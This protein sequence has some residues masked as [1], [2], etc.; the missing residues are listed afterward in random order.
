MLPDISH[1]CAVRRQRGKHH[2]CGRGL[3][4]ELPQCFGAAMQEPVIPASLLTPDTLGVGEDQQVFPILGPRVVFNLKR[5]GLTGRNKL[6]CRDQ[7]FAMPGCWMIFY[8]VFDLFAVF[9]VF[10]IFRDFQ[11]GVARAVLQPVRR[12]PAFRLEFLFQA[13][14]AIHRQPSARCGGGW[15]VLTG[16]SCGMRLRRISW[17]FGNYFGG[18]HRRSDTVER[19]N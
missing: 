15:R 13:K 3:A 2:G 18:G 5:I 12:P 6:L 8:D 11:S 14:D 4:T 9:E 16:L 10:E 19:T 7:D 1:A 17:R